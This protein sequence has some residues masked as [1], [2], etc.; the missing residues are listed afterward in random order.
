MWLRRRSSMR[1]CMSGSVAF[2]FAGVVL[3][4]D[5]ILEVQPE[6]CMFNNMNARS[7]RKLLREA[8]TAAG[9]E[10]AFARQAG[11]TQQLV[12]LVLTGRREPRGKILD[13]LGL[14]MVV[15]FRKKPN[16]W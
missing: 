3:Y 10:S 1:I 13:V 12:S 11:V 8:C 15:E 14:K 16:D 7:V 5:S 4:S 6:S 2:Y 9:G